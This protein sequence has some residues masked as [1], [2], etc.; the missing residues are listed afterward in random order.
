MI[1]IQDEWKFIFLFSYIPNIRKVHILQTTFYE[2]V[3]RIFPTA[4]SLYIWRQHS[5]ILVLIQ[6]ALTITK[7]RNIERMVQIIPFLI[8][9]LTYRLPPH[10]VPIAVD[11]ICPPARTKWRGQR[12]DTLYTKATKKAFFCQKILLVLLWFGCC[13]CICPY[14]FCYYSNNIF[15]KSELAPSLFRPGHKLRLAELQT[16]EPESIMFICILMGLYV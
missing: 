12:Y 15:S 4:G 6:M 14:C 5:I 11:G 9:S 1:N 13:Y 10:R 7:D 16:A 8:H 2:Y 3:N